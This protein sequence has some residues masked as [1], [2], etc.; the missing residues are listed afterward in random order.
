MKYTE[1]E[2]DQ[3]AIHYGKWLLENIHRYNGKDADYIYDMYQQRE[4]FIDTEEI[5]LSELAENLEKVTPSLVMLAK[6]Q[7]KSTDRE[8]I[9]NWIKSNDVV[10]T[11]KVPANI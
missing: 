3:H 10:I 5:E 6:E 8:T 2:L 4:E 7:T 9:A 11:G 1:K